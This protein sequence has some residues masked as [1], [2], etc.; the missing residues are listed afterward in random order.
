MVDLTSCYSCWLPRCQAGD[1]EPASLVSGGWRREGQRAGKVW[2]GYYREREE[3]GDGLLVGRFSNGRRVGCHWRRDK[4]GLWTVASVDD[5]GRA[6]GEGVVVYPDLTT[7]LVGEFKG[8]HLVAGCSGH[9]AGVSLHLGVPWLQTTSVEKE[10]MP[11]CT[12]S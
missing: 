4:G 12:N 5:A 3:G 9:L 6:E 8:G 1:T 2:H 10:V 7:L 11:P